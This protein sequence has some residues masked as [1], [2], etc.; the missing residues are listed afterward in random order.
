MKKYGAIHEDDH[1]LPCTR[2][3]WLEGMVAAAECHARIVAFEICK[4]LVVSGMV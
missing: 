3:H 4:V 2:I 1:H